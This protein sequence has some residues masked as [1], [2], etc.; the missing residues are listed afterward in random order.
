MKIRIT[1]KFKIQNGP[2]KTKELLPG[3]YV[4][5]KD[6]S[7]YYAEL[8]LR[9]GKAEVIAEPKVEKVAPENKVI[10]VAENKSRVAKKPVR[11]R[12]TRPK[13]DK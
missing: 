3:E 7:L 8:V 2:R 9:F 11:R 6:I 12:S 5:G 4:V 13:P 10:E 1:R